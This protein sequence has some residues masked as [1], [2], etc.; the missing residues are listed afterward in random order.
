M[1]EIFYEAKG[2]FNFMNASVSHLAEDAPL[3]V[4]TE[5]VEPMMLTE[6][7]SRTQDED[8]MEECLEAYATIPKVMQSYD[9]TKGMKLS[10]WGW[11]LMK[12]A[13]LKFIAKADRRYGVEFQY[14]HWSDEE[15]N[16]EQ[17][18]GAETSWQSDRGWFGEP[19]GENERALQWRKD[20]EAVSNILEPR[21]KKILGWMLEGQT[22]Q[23]MADKLGIS[24][25]R[26]NR[27]ISAMEGT[28]RRFAG[29]E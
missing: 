20:Y 14:D 18:P 2:M 16:P 1:S 17:E 27:L 23:Y 6:F 26:V 9:E 7:P 24:Q 13:V 29:L 25:S 22:Q 21:E 12:N 19:S 3:R 28:I 15:S 11:R 4:L 8:F 10:S 5:L